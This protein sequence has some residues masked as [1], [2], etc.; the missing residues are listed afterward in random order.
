MRKSGLEFLKVRVFWVHPQ[1]YACTQSNDFTIPFFRKGYLFVM[2]SSCRIVSQIDTKTVDPFLPELGKLQLNAQS[3][4]LLSHSSA[5]PVRLNRHK[6]GNKNGENRNPNRDKENLIL[7][8]ERLKRIKCA[9]HP[10]PPTY[11][12]FA[13]SIRP[14]SR[15]SASIATSSDLS[16]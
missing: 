2:K 7:T 12:R 9:H 10:F 16:A 6:P 4:L 1:N 15:T 13:S 11:R 8:N 5:C 14:M 3:T